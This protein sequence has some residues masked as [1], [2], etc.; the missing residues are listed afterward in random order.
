MVVHEMNIIV[1]GPHRNAMADHD[2]KDCCISTSHSGRGGSE[3]AGEGERQLAPLSQS[4]KSCDTEVRRKTG[5]GQ[6]SGPGA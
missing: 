5:L 1:D 6:G 3:G 4:G 2:R